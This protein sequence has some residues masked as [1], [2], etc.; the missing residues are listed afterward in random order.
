MKQYFLLGLTLCAAMVF[1]GCKSK[2]SAYR[3]AYE[4]AKAQEQQATTDVTSQQTTTPAVTPVQTTT[5]TTN[6]TVDH[7]DVRTI[8]GGITVVAGSNLKAYSVVVGSFVNQ[9]NAV[10]L[11]NTLNNL[12]YN[13]T[14]VKTNETIKGQTGWFRVIASS[15]DTK[16]QAANSRDELR[17]SYPG[18]WLLYNK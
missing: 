12:G 6:T 13:A 15:F 8:P 1:T 2:D 18:S 10:G 3:E 17:S 14:V 5:T 16:D 9:T 4:R 7:S 11:M